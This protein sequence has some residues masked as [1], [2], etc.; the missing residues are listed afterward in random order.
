MLTQV[1]AAQRRRLQDEQ[2]Q[3]EYKRRQR[4]A[5]ARG[6]RGDN[7]C[8]L[9]GQEMKTIARQRLRLAVDIEKRAAAKREALEELFNKYD[10]NKSGMLEEDQVIM[11]LTDMDDSTPPGTQ[12]TDEQVDFVLKVVNPQSSDALQLSELENALRIWGSYTQEKDRLH[13][14]FVDY[15]KNKSG[16]LEKKELKAYLVYLNQ[17]QPVSDREVD[18]VLAQADIFGDGDIREIEMIA[19]TSAWHAIP[20]AAL[21]PR[22]D[23][24]PCCSVM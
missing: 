16:R 23:V 7:P 10:T 12:P 14:V 2:D 1:V 22:D 11:L 19:A 3:V 17:G 8:L 9:S 20:D 18:W 5:E 4:L 21:I 6:R 13:K 15:D 24:Q